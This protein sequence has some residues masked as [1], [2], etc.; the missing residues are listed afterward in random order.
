M[1]SSKIIQLVFISI[2][3][4][5][6]SGFTQAY[7][8]ERNRDRVYTLSDV[9]GRYAFSFD[10]EIIGLGPIAATGYIKSDGKG[11]ITEAERTIATVLG[12]AT[13]E[14]F[15]CTYD[16]TNNGTGSSTCTLD[17]SGAVET[18]NYV[19]EDN[20]KGFRLVGTTPGVILLGGGHR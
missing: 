7:A 17:A 4:V 14:T 15:T 16:I 18:F 10:G 19:L 12:P 3:L 2:L 9:K 13:I 5:I 1:T 11:N 6:A 8:D 20:G